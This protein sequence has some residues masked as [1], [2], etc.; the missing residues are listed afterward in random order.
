MIVTEVICDVRESNNFVRTYAP[1]S[2]IKIESRADSQAV[3]QAVFF[4][5]GS[6]PWRIIP[7]TADGAEFHDWLE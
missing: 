1:Y 4:P 7:A 3:F 5:F 6:D 2:R